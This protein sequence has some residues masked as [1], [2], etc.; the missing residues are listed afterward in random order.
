MALKDIF[1]NISE[2]R[3]QDKEEFKKMEKEFRFKKLLEE[4]QKS[5]MQ[6]EH[7]FYV[8]EQERVKLK[9]MV[10][11]ERHQRTEKFKELSNP[12][13]KGNSLREKNDIIKSDVHWI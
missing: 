9:K 13:N 1:R 8:K 4:K 10:E 12:F 11:F 5:P 6:K 7:E 2:K 3:K